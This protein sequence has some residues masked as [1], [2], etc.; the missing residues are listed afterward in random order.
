MPAVTFDHVFSKYIPTD[1]YWRNS[2]FN[3]KY[4]Q[5]YIL[6]QT[7]FYFDLFWTECKKAKLY[8]DL[9]EEINLKQNEAQS[10]CVESTKKLISA[11]NT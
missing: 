7:L 2:D 5:W 9:L 1:H 3:W 4:N 11:W 8:S 6:K 10:T